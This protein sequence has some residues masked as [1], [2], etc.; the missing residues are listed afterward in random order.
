MGT[1]WSRAR[2]LVS[3]RQR[4]QDLRSE[5]ESHLEEA[6]EE[7]RRQGFPPAEAR[8]A[9][10]VSFGGIAQTEEA[11]REQQAFAWVDHSLREARHAV[12]SLRRSAG[13]SVS[14]LLVLAIGTGAVTA[15]FVLLNSIVL[16]PLPY[17]R[18]DRL[19]LL[20][21]TT[22]GPDRTAGGV[23]SA[24]YFHYLDHARSLESVGTYN[25][26]VRNLRVDDRTER[27]R[28]TDVSA[29]LLEVLGVKPALGRLFTAED[30]RPG[31]MSLRWRIPILLSHDFWVDRFG[32]DPNIIGRVITLP[33]SPREV[34]GVMPAGFSFPNAETQIWMLL[35]PMRSTRASLSDLELNTIARLHGTATAA[36]AQ[37]ELAHLLPQLE[38]SVGNASAEPASGVD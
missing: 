12:R 13:F 22:P 20:T 29:T 2:S 6:A 28:V 21:H 27:V 35:E 17:P 38:A 3:R 8:R 19:V 15:I 37:A 11:Y 16:R 9:A 25:E 7:Y 1:L 34:I 23:S 4:V 24:L 26:T 14:V 36:S 10:M 32:A 18:S 31:F 30:G 33:D 5:I